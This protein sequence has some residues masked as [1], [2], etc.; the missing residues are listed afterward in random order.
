MITLRLLQ[1]ISLSRERERER[2][3]ERGDDTSQCISTN[4]ENH[5]RQTRTDTNRVALLLIKCLLLTNIRH[6]LIRFFTE[7]L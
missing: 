2:E 6:S 5:Y 3:R 1:I 4:I 7:Y